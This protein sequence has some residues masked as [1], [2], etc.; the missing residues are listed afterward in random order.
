M[1]S[2]LNILHCMFFSNLRCINFSISREN[3]DNLLFSY[4]SI[5]LLLFQISFFNFYKIYQSV[6]VFIAKCSETVTNFLCLFSLSYFPYHPSF[7]VHSVQGLLLF[8]NVVGGVNTI[9]IVVK[10]LL[11]G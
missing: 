4:F 8:Y 3:F 9:G 11:C 10:P 5:F 2:T 1:A 7:H 6:G